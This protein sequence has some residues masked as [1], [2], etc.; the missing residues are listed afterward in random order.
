M[1]FLVGSFTIF[2]KLSSVRTVTAVAGLAILAFPPVLPF[3]K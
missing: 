3:R 1:T 2:S